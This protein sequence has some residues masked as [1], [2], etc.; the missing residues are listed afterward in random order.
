[1]GQ[2]WGKDMSVIMA[3]AGL[4]RF[5]MEYDK[6]LIEKLRDFFGAH[7]PYEVMNERKKVRL[8]ITTPC[9]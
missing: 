9:C 3:D 2:A 7:D 4:K 6:L 5:L 8:T 1:M